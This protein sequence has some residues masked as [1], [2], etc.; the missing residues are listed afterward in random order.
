VTRRP[1]PY[2][3]EDCRDLRHSWVR[4]SDEVLY[5]EGNAHLFTRTV[6]C[7]RCD[8]TRID[9]YRVPPGGRHLL[10]RVGSRYKYPTGYVVKGGYDVDAMRWRLFQGATYLRGMTG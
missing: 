8:T 10:V 2:H 7:S 6:L 4:Q 1:P 3:F 5:S 9:T